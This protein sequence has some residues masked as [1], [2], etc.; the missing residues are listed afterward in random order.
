MKK[1]F[2]ICTIVFLVGL[3]PLVTHADG[4]INIDVP[5]GCTVTDTANVQHVFPQGDSP[6]DYLGV[7]MLETAKE[8][9]LL[10]FTLT[11]DP[12][13]GLYIQSVN[14]ISPG[15]TEYWA[16][17]SNGVMALCGIGCI[18]LLQDDTISLI[19]TDWMTNVESTTVALQ[20]HSLIS[21]PP[22]P[23]PPSGGGGGIPNSQ[24]NIANALAYLANEQREDGSFGSS[25]LSDWVAIAFVA[26]D[27]GD[28]KVKLT[29]YMRTTAPALSN[30]TDYERHAMALLA[31]GIDPYSRTPADYITPIVNAF[32]GKQ[33]G[34]AS[35]DND[36]IFALFPLLHAGYNT[37]DTLI[38]KTIAFILSRQ[39][40][41]GSWD[42]SADMTA[43]AIQSLVQVRMLPDVSIALIR[44]EGYLRGER[45]STN[46]FS[47]SW[48]RQ[49][50]S[51]LS[52]TPS[53]WT[54][55]SFTK[56][57][58]L[59][60]LQQS[61]GGVE[62]ESSGTQTRVW[63]TAY[64]IPAALGKSWPMLL[65]SFPKS[66]ATSTPHV[67]QVTQDMETA[68]TTATT[69]PPTIS[70]NANTKAETR[71]I[72]IPPPPQVAAVA[73]A[74]AAGFFASLWSVITSFFINLLY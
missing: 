16:I 24:L 33:I 53:G 12:N 55:N 8:A 60:E 73:S 3:L 49:A 68:T 21:P 31:L 25:L 50:I 46:S 32:D 42:G 65:Q 17:W 74:P 70:R 47:T 48:V 72:K 37:N 69:S 62:P 52:W 64:A 14:G 6:S 61:D 40:Q 44:A 28:A 45:P 57:D 22:P 59:A 11:N 66:A 71:V 29:E 9:G 56:D 1:V 19:L 13:L 38:Q 36:D 7:C 23:P 5:N 20:V 18:P 43:A 34:D 63:A 30:V 41:N 10:G 67:F 15:A 39:G 35:L 26:A 58:Y 54:P 51:A 27:P 4:P 2:N